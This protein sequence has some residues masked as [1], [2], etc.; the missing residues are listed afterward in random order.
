MGA[1][2]G[3]LSEEQICKKTLSIPKEAGHSGGSRRRHDDVTLESIEKTQSGE[4]SF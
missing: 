3:S 1:N 2:G 4:R